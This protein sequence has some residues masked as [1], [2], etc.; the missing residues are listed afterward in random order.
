MRTVRTLAAALVLAAA[1]AG[2]SGSSNSP[3]PKPTSTTA[4]APKPTSTTAP[5]ASPALSA[6]E[7]K[8]ACV[9]AVV[10]QVTKDPGSLRTEPRPAGCEGLEDAT[11]LEAYY[12]ALKKAGGKGGETGGAAPSGG[13]TG[14]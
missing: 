3:D 5:S 8:K 1:L 6:E 13:S 14:G 11:Y 4:P 7:Q 9:A 12:E 2:C 10:G